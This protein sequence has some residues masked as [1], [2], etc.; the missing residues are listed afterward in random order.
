MSVTINISLPKKMYEDIKRAIKVKSYTSVSELIRASVRKSLYE[1]VTE[2]GFTPA[3]EDQVLE[4]AMEP[5]ENDEVWETEDDVRKYFSQL[6]EEL[7]NKNVKNKAHRQVQRYA[8]KSLQR[9]HTDTNQGR[10][11]NRPFYK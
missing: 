11:D 4:S 2:N 8:K 7:Q 6:R 1:E 5:E 3:F 10:G 9:K